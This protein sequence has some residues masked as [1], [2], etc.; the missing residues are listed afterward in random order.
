LTIA[1][2]FGPA[3]FEAAKAA[4][5]ATSASFGGRPDQVEVRPCS[6]TGEHARAGAANGATAAVHH[7]HLAFEQR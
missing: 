2:V 6:S 4:V 3:R 1:P 7:G 5:S